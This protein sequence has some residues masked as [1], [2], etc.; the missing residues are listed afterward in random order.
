MSDP[1]ISAARGAVAGIRE[2]L[3]VGKEVE[4]LAEDIG[5][6]GVAEVQARA[7]YRRK[8]Q[9]VKG[10]ATIVQAINEWRRVK[11]IEDLE[12]D[13][14]VDITAK[15][16]A[17]EWDKVIAIKDRM[18]KEHKSNVDEYGRDL[19]K[20]RTLKWWCFVAAFFLTFALYQKGLL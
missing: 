11:Q 5:K 3:E 14:K 13:L 16:G 17:A 15:F 18:V 19:A 9:V 20:L 6:L 1:V 2:A 8:K 7:A 12:K 4:A 10:D